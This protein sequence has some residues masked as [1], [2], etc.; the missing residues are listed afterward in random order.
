MAPAQTKQEILLES[1]TNEVEIA[2]INLCG[3]NFGVNVAKIREFIPY[4]GI[5]LSEL[6]GRHPSV[7]GV[8]MLRGTAIPLISL[9]KH[10]ELNR[11]DDEPSKKVVVV[12]QFNNMTTAFVADTINRIHR[13]SWNQF[14]P[15]ELHIASKTPMIVGSVHLKDREL[16]ILDLEHIVGEIFPASIIN[17]DEKRF[18]EKP[19]PTERADAKLVFAEDSAIIRYRV[20]GI[21]KEVGYENVQIFEHGQAAYDY[22]SRLVRDEQEGKGAVRDRLSLVLTDIEM[23]QMDGLTLCRR[24]REDLKLDV[25]VVMFSSLIDEQMQQKC[26]SV[27]AND[28]AAKPDTE[29]LIDILDRLCLG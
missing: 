25:P 17:Y 4:E 28:F 3:Q 10:L 2:E 8:F 15:L 16:L 13:V 22:L 9:E 29:R 27:G 14:R 1:G 6:P 21:L 12:T 19:K 24:I 7:L 5:E 18:A 11:K 23:P 20:S 26:L